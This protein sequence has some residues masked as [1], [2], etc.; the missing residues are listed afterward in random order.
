MF[1]ELD[2]T[3]KD[4]PVYQA[5]IHDVAT[6]FQRE[7][8]V[9]ESTCYRRYLPGT[10]RSAPRV[11]FFVLSTVNGLQYSLLFFIVHNGL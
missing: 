10:D 6:L 4:S 8:H 2:S 3:S 7:K 11:S 1:N 5:G 9:H